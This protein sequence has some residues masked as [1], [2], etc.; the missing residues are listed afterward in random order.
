MEEIERLRRQANMVKEGVERG[1]EEIRVRRWQFLMN[2]LK[3]AN[4]IED[5]IQKSNKETETALELMEQV[6]KLTV[7]GYVRRDHIANPSQAQGSGHNRW[8]APGAAYDD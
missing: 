8:S 7:W 4:K 6:V 2:N 1:I 5:L 3:E